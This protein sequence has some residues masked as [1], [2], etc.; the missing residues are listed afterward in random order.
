MTFK[1]LA[2][3]VALTLLPALSY[4][5]GCSFDRQAMSC[6]E[7]SVYDAESGTCVPTVNS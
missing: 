2:A 1:T 4:A 6:A 7:G 3:A 5:A